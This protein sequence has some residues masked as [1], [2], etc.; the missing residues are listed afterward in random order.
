MSGHSARS[1]AVRCHFARSECFLSFCNNA[2]TGII[3]TRVAEA[4]ATERAINEAREVYRPVP[5]RGSLLYFVTAELSAI[6][7]MYQTSLAAFVRMFGHCLDAAPRADDLA[8][9]LRVLMD[10]TTDYVYRSV[11]RWVRRRGLLL[12]EGGPGGCGARHSRVRTRSRSVNIV[13]A[14]CWVLTALHTPVPVRRGLFDSHKLLYSF[15]ISAAVERQAGVVSPAEWNYLLRGGR[16]AAAAAGGPASG[17]SGGGYGAGGGG[18]GA[19]FQP[20]GQA[21]AAAGAAASFQLPV[22]APPEMAAWAPPGCWDA[23]VALEAAVPHVFGG[24]PMAVAAHVSWLTRMHRIHVSCCRNM[25]GH[26][27]YSSLFYT[28]LL[29]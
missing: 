7:P 13:C 4:E 22:S 23:L 25:V 21:G 14:V 11:C 26:W 5:A 15:L 12:L 3:A 28:A 6:D 20:F 24:L 8:A 16:G 17:A 2:R 18:G 29:F 10:T 1:P 9:R 19:A 27:C